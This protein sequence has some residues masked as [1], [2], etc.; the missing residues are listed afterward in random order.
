[1][2]QNTKP[3]LGKRVALGV[4]VGL[5]IGETIF[6]GYLIG[7]DKGNDEAQETYRPLI[8]VYEDSIETLRDI[9]QTQ[10]DLHSVE[11][12]YNEIKKQLEKLRGEQ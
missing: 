3:S 2:I 8:G 4:G 9:V 7:K 12:E 1:M 11:I 5:A 10:R 6:C